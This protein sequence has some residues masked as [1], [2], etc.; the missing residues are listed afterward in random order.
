VSKFVLFVP[1]TARRQLRDFSRLSTHCGRGILIS[2]A[3]NRDR[4]NGSGTGIMEKQIHTKSRFVFPALYV[5]FTLG[6]GMNGVDE[7]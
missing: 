1:A 3:R 4:D 6:Q 2:P 7:C 5:P